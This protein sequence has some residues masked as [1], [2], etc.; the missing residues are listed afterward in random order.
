[1]KNIKLGVNI[2]HIATVRNA[3]GG[4]HPNIICAA[5]IVEAS[6]AD[7]L[8][9]HVREDRRHINEHDL[10]NILKVINI[11][12]NLEIAANKEMVKIANKYKPSSVCFVPEK[13]QEITTEGGLDIIKNYDNLKDIINNLYDDI[14]VAFFIDPDNEQLKASYELGVKT[15][16][17]H[18]GMYANAYFE[19]TSSNFELDKLKKTASLGEKINVKCAA[20]HGLNFDN[21]SNVASI[22]HISEL[23]IGHFLVGDA[24]FNGLENSIKKMINILK[25]SVK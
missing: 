22:P 5:K 17:L 19:N 8:T 4:E 3:R 23:N 21:V 25:E 12:L 10:E 6:G 11:P 9:V 24:I 18:T 20:G 15:V 16:E 1:M 7:Q 14:D 13:R 2:D